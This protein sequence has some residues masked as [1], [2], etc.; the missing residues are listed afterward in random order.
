MY[1]RI[2]DFQ[3][4]NAGVIEPQSCYYDDH[5][6]ADFKCCGPLPMGP[7]GEPRRYYK[8]ELFSI[9]AITRVSCFQSMVRFGFHYGTHRSCSSGMRYY[10]YNDK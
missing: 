1:Q 7:G 2:N 4:S 9:F 6:P 8:G 5:C 3:S 10:H